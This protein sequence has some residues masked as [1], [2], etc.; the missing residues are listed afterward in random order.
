[1]QVNVVNVVH[2]YIRFSIDKGVVG[3]A[4]KTGELQNITDAQMCEYFN[5]EVDALTG[6]KTKTLLCA[7]LIVQKK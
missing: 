4:A 7:P 6:Y 5:S 3:Y 2:T 1:M